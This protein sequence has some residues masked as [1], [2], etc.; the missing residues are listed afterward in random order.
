[1]R[2]TIVETGS[3]ALLAAAL[4]QRRIVELT[5]AGRR[6][7]VEPHVLGTYHGRLQ[8]LAYQVA[9][10]SSSGGLPE[11]RRF[12]VDRIFRVQLLES[13]FGTRPAR[14][15]ARFDEVIAFVGS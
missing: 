11:W 13:H 5:Y 6:R 8:L 12:D 1:M 9:G 10:Q 2:S 14:D 4:A 7:V 15:H 3:R